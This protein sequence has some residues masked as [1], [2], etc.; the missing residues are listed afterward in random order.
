MKRITELRREA[1]TLQQQITVTEANAATR[2]TDQLR[3]RM[4]ELRAESNRVVGSVLHSQQAVDRAFAYQSTI[5]FPP[6]VGKV[7]KE[8]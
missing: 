8:V 1:T 6:F 2:E 4:R 5:W 7:R 3:M